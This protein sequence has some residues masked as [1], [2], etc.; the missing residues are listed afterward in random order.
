MATAPHNPRSA[1][2]RTRAG[3]LLLAAGILLISF[4]L[5][6]SM[7][8]VGPLANE[9]RE[10]MGLSSSAVGL[11]T[12]LPLLAF[13]VVSLLIPL[14][15]RRFGGAATLAMAMV[16][17]T[18][19]ILL[20]S[21]PSV[22]ALFAG[23]L[24]LGIAI[25]FGNV[26][27]PGLVKEHFS[28]RFGLMTSL[29]SS[30][31]SVGASLAAGISIPL[32]AKLPGGWRASLASWAVWAFLALLLWLPQLKRSRPDPGSNGG[33]LGS[34][35]RMGRSRLAWNVALFMGLQ[36][37]VFYVVLAWL[38]DML[39]S[40]GMEPEYAGW[41]LSLSQITSVVG[42]LLIPVWAV[43]RPDQR[44][45]VAFLFAVEFLSLLGL[46]LPGMGPA[47]LWVA[48][49][50]INLG[51]AFSLTLYMIGVR[52]A[53]T[54]TA[55]ELSGL[56]QSIGYLVAAAGPFVA[57]SLFDFTGNWTYALVLLALISCS[58]LY[59]GLGAARDEVIGNA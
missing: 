31:L 43:R 59:V 38:P 28:S 25:A 12:T 20:R 56:A 47:E 14:A 10:A 2:P 48:L 15:T 1:A 27:L 5:R 46:M 23:T 42:S 44:R 3:L 57:G 29:Y 16:L 22:L 41:M 7:A 49:L 35:K 36:S 55:N 53:D 39:Q 21:A 32:A 54:A 34:L 45:I 9:I 8:A 18:V 51:G 33:Y 13:G 52:A 50:G 4:N 6:A 30:L 40:R 26:L 19:G 17:L 11:L 24:L 58:R 37:F